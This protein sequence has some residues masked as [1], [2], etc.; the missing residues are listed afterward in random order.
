MYYQ[1]PQLSLQIRVAA[2][3][4]LVKQLVGIT[5][6]RKVYAYKITN[7]NRGVCLLYTTNTG[8]KKVI[9]KRPVS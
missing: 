2:F 6:A 7:K 4:S 9:R 5:S 8:N 1:L 3:H